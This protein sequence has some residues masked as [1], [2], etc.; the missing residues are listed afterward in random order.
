MV[1]LIIAVLAAMVT[2]K[3]EGGCSDL[4]EILQQSGL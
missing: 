4:E 2:H 3:N 1:V